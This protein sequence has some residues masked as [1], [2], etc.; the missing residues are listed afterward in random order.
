VSAVGFDDPTLIDPL[1]AILNNLTQELEAS[2][3]ISV[4]LDL[5]VIKDTRLYIYIYIYN[6]YLIDTDKL[7]M[8]HYLVA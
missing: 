1:S 8:F 6:V 4:P 3:N 5:K 2:D 7:S